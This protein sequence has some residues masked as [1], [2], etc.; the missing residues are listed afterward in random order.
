MQTL[1]AEELLATQQENSFTYVIFD[2]IEL[3]TIDFNYVLQT[4]PET[5]RRSANGKR[6]LVKWY[7]PPA[8]C[9]EALATKGPYMTQDQILIIMATPEWTPKDPLDV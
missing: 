4:S 9:I 3:D 6:T 2:V 5:C 7:G 8:A 1:T